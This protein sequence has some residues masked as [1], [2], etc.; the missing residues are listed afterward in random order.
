MN[1]RTRRLV[2]AA[3]VAIVIGTG[4]PEVFALGFRNPDQ[5]AARHG[6]RQRI[7]RPSGRRHGGV[8]QSGR[9]H[10]DPWD[11]DRQ[12]RRPEFPG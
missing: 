11:R 6:A 1:K 2:G 4:M 5:G 8:L 7:H 3:A 10:P 9:S 12:R